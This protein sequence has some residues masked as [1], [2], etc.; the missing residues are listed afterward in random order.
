M[1]HKVY[2]VRAQRWAMVLIWF[3]PFLWT[4]NIVASRQAPGVVSPHVLALGRWGLA[5]SILTLVSARELWQHRAMLW[6]Q[7]WRYL[8]MGGCGMWICGAWVYLAGESTV[9]MNISLIYASAPVLIALGSVLWLNEHFSVRQR[10][11]VALAMSGVVHVVVKG[12]WASLSAVKLVPGDLWIVGAAIA[13]AAY[14]L[15]QRRWPSVMSS[16]AQLA[17]TCMGGV[18]VILP[19]A[20]WELMSSHTPV[21]GQQALGL[22]VLTALLPGVMAYWIYGWAQKVLGASRVAVTLYLG[23]LYTA[24]VAWGVLKEPLGVFHWVGGLLI[25]SGVALVMLAR[26]R[27]A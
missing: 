2:S 24:V 23:P 5:G 1:S 18:T 12:Q 11:G 6:Q 13:W 25:L 15:L 26:P 9:S 14:A 4:V 17:A 10:L 3:V 16:T 22:M 27:A 20:L 19:F 7:R 8:L 21:V